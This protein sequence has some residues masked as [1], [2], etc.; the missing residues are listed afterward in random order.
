MSG[1]DA[2]VVGTSG[3]LDAAARR[4]YVNRIRWLAGALVVV[5]LAAVLV[6]RFRD[7][8]FQALV[9]GGGMTTVIAADVGQHGFFGIPPFELR[10]GKPVRIRSITVL[11]VPEGLHVV[12]VYATPIG[13]SMLGTSREFD[14]RFLFPVNRAEFQKG[15]QPAWYFIVDLRATTRG[16]F[17]TRG[18]DVAWQ[19]GHHKGHTTYNYNFGIEP[20]RG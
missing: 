18:I 3:T 9:P 10:T 17:T 1:L 13:Y 14:R 15:R 20:P 12:G 7:S 19:A 2:D 11:G 5:A 6:A 16:R 8:G 4:R